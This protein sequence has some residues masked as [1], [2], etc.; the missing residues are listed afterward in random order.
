MYN[1]TVV[2]KMAFAPSDAF[3]CLIVITQTDAENGDEVKKRI[4]F[5]V[6]V[7]GEKFG[8]FKGNL[9]IWTLN[10]IQVCEIGF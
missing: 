1:E 3:E 6:S 4:H 2:K 7:N 9:P 5:D 8:D 10:W